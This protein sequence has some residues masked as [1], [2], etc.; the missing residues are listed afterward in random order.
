MFVLRP[1]FPLLLCIYTRLCLFDITNPV[2]RGSRTESSFVS[3]TVKALQL[4]LKGELL[5]GTCQKRRKIIKEALKLFNP[6]MKSIGVYVGILRR[7]CRS[8]PHSYL[9]L[10]APLVDICKCSANRYRAMF[11]PHQQAKRSQRLAVRDC[12]HGESDSK[13][14]ENLCCSRL[15]EDVSRL[16][17]WFHAG[18]LRGKTRDLLL[19]LTD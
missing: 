3:A 8:S 15:V 18:E 10:Q 4:I 6:R 16:K 12:R 2:S 7:N 11:I 14:H 5:A 1:L 19:S 9:V 17:I 13:H